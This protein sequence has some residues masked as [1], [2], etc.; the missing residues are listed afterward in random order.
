MRR[1]FPPG[2]SRFSPRQSTAIGTP[3]SPC[4][5]CVSLSLGIQ[6]LACS[7]ILVSRHF[8]VT[9]GAL[10]LLCRR[11]LTLHL[12]LN[13]LRRSRNIARCAIHRAGWRMFLFSSHASCRLAAANRC[14]SGTRVLQVC[15]AA[16]G[17]AGAS[18]CAADTQDDDGATRENESFRV[19]LLLLCS[20]QARPGAAG[21]TENRSD[22]RRFRV[23]GEISLLSNQA[24]KRLRRPQTKIARPSCDHR[25]REQWVHSSRSTSRCRQQLRKIHD[26]AN[27]HRTP[28]P[29]RQRGPERNASAGSGWMNSGSTIAM[30]RSTSAAPGRG[31]ASAR[32]PRWV[33]RALTPRRAERNRTRDRCGSGRG[34][35]DRWDSIGPI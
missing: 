29:R 22:C 18:H 17:I 28:L 30:C 34:C 11:R 20:R 16:A 12:F 35:R 13:I 5:S 3:G 7:T 23:A 25:T 1:Y 26:V 15:G 33:D 10:G 24:R 9:F 2:Q 4:I 6:L 27:P 14:G 21:R 8:V 32:M 19:H 31:R